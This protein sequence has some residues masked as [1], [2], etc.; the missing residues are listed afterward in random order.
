MVGL[1]LAAPTDAIDYGFAITKRVSATFGGPNALAEYLSISIALTSGVLL[2]ARSRAMLWLAGSGFVLEAAA[3]VA[4]QSRGGVLAAIFGVVVVMW[5]RWRRR[6]LSTLAVVGVAGSLG[7]LSLQV[8]TGLSNALANLTDWRQIAVLDRLDIWQMALRI[9]RDS[10]VLGIG[11]GAF[12]DEAL[13]RGL[14]LRVP[15]GY[16]G[17]HAHNTFLEVATG[18][19]LL[20]LVAFGLLLAWGAFL[21]W[22]SLTRAR[23]VA[24]TELAAGACGALATYM[25]YSMFDNLLARSIT[26]LLVIVLTFAS[27]TARNRVSRGLEQST[28]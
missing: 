13:S 3:L 28:Q 23:S 8:W 6:F 24:A 10:P 20:G 22:H 12:R 18:M 14:T 26:P 9:V 15:L 19:G 25:L 17:L 5:I 11:V 4:T 7:L 21:A 16:G 1:D 27:P 2:S